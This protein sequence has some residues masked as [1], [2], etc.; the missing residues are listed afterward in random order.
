MK[1]Q[2]TLFLL[3][4]SIFGISHAAVIHFNDYETES[5]AG[6]NLNP[7]GMDFSGGGGDHDGQPGFGISTANPRS[8]TY[9]YVVDNSATSDNGNGW[10]ATWSGIQSDGAN[11]TTN[12]ITSQAN[13]MANATAAS[14]LSYVNIAAGTTFTISSWVATDSANALLGTANTSV[15]IELHNSAGTEVARHLSPALGVT[16]LSETYQEISFSYTITQADID[17]D[18]VRA[19]GVVGTD[20]HGF[21]NGSGVILIDDVTFSVDDASIVTIPEPSAI[22]LS[23]LGVFGLSLR[24]RR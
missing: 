8:G 1:L 20:G 11:A 18:V 7:I 22:L 21:N 10:G 24:R 5:A 17:A 15:R 3:A 23:V 9:S 4:S 6:L 2:T 12:G 14:P 13:A 19:T 16:D